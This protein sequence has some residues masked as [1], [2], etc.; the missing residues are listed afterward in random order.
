MTFEEFQR[1]YFELDPKE[2]G[3]LAGELEFLVSLDGCLG[4]SYNGEPIPHISDDDWGL[5]LDRVMEFLQKQF[6]SILAP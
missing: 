4:A 3:L 6:V 1:A 2:D 5:V